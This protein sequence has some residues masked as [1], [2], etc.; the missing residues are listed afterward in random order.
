MTMRRRTAG[1]RER[2]VD[3]RREAA[4][5]LVTDN[6]FSDRFVHGDADQRRGSRG[7]GIVRGKGQRFARG[8]PAV[9]AQAGEIRSAA[10]AG[11]AAH[12]TVRR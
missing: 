5:Q 2:I 11:I 12:Q 8:A 7:S 3:D 9:P 1:L 4:A 6:G 10:Q